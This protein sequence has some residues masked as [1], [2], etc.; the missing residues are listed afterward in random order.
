[1]HPVHSA[2]EELIPIH[3]AHAHFVDWE[4]AKLRA[5]FFTKIGFP[6]AHPLR[7]A[8]DRVGDALE[9]HRIAACAVLSDFVRRYGDFT[10]KA[11]GH[12]FNTAADWF[13]NGANLSW[14]TCD[15]WVLK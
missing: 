2:L 14:S 1:M 12:V 8:V 6:D 15:A 4:R 13:R 3:L 11:D 7:V 9:D 10:A 5:E